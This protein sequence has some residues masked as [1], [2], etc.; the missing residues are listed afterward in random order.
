MVLASRRERRGGGGGERILA[1]LAKEGRKGRNL[2]RRNFPSSPSAR[3]QTEPMPGE[4]LKKR[5]YN[6]LLARPLKDSP[7]YWKN[8][9]KGGQPSLSSSEPEPAS[10]RTL[11]NIKVR[12][13]SG[14]LAKIPKQGS[15][16]SETIDAPPLLS[17][18]SIGTD[19]Y[20]FPACLLWKTSR[21][22]AATRR[23]FAHS[24]TKIGRRLSRSRPSLNVCHE[25]TTTVTV[26]KEFWFATIKSC[27]ISVLCYPCFETYKFI[28]LN[29]F[30]KHYYSKIWFHFTNSLQSL[31]VCNV[32]L[33]VYPCFETFFVQNYIIKWFY[34]ALF[35][36]Y[37]LTEVTAKDEDVSASIKSTA[38]LVF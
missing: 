4:S 22:F 11:V 37:S 31:T 17:A 7:R 15:L 5:I 3:P 26:H 35:S 6:L 12:I 13:L 14:R 30:I 20:W 29:N 34:K 19:L 1:K 38:L 18:P 32:G 36:L 8:I 9:R 33:C 2:S 10:S 25:P 24:A 23:I 27:K 16:F 28:S 21:G